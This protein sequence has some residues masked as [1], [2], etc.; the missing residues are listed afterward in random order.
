[1]YGSVESCHR[2]ALHCTSTRPPCP[3]A[4]ADTGQ[5]LNPC[6]V[7]DDNRQ[8]ASECGC[9]GFRLAR[10]VW[11]IFYASFGRSL[12]PRAALLP[13]SRI[14]SRSGNRFSWSTVWARVLSRWRSIG[15]IETIRFPF[16]GALA[17]VFINFMYARWFDIRFLSSSIYMWCIRFDCPDCT[18]SQCADCWVVGFQVRGGKSLPGRMV[19]REQTKAMQRCLVEFD[20]FTFAPES[21]VPRSFRGLI[22]PSTLWALESPAPV[23]MT[24]AFRFA[25]H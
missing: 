18:S 9:A 4:I 16:A 2:H 22:L 6:A 20:R 13:V 21:L 10:T 19:D 3:P 7:R 15:S 1:M 8:R 23:P 14:T 12:L 24:F 11:T 5:C 25:Y 17:G